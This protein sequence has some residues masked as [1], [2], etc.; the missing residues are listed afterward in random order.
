MCG[1]GGALTVDADEAMVTDSTR[2]VTKG[3]IAPGS[4][5]SPGSVYSQTC[6]HVGITRRELKNPDDQAASQTNELRMSW[7]QGSV[8]LNR[9]PKLRQ[10]WRTTVLRIMKVRW[11][12]KPMNTEENTAQGVTSAQG[13]C[14]FVS[15][16]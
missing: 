14:A 16:Q 3:R 8:I 9:I 5:A 13:V 2:P 1:V 6:L 4:T 12:H 10:V 7:G 15:V 11:S